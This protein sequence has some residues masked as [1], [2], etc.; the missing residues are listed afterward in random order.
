MGFNG[1]LAINISSVFGIVVDVRYNTDDIVTGTV[2]NN[3]D[4]DIHVNYKYTDFAVLAGPR[5]AFR[6]SEKVTPFVHALI[7]LDR[8]KF[9]YDLT[10][11]VTDSSEEVSN[12]LGVAVGGGFDANLGDNVALRLA[13]VDYYLMTHYEELIKN[14]AFSGGI[15]FRFGW[16]Y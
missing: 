2:T 3:D 15:V 4:I 7:G 11:T 12:G 9:S 14:I 8:G 6:N 16:T 10:G 1:S 13:Q 5:L